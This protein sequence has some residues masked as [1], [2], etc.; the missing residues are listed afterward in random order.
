M[1]KNDNSS[2][3]ITGGV[4]SSNKMELTEMFDPDST[5][6]VISIPDISK[7]DYEEESVSV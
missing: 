5:W 3:L 6:D 4:N 2:L 1:I 7:T